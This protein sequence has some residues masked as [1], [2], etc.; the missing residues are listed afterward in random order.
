M[1]QNYI[2]IFH[3]ITRQKQVVIIGFL[4][5][6]M[7]TMHGANLYSR[8]NADFNTAGTWS[9]A[10]CG[11]ASCGC[12]PGG[13]DDIDICAGYY[14]TS[15]ATFTLGNGGTITINT[16]ATLDF[17]SNAVVIGNGATLVINGGTL[18]TGD[19]TF[20]NGSTVSVNATGSIAVTGNFQNK[21]NSN[22]I[23]INGFMGVSGWASFGNG[24]TMTGT[25]AISITGLSSGAGT[26][27][28]MLLPEEPEAV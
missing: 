18:I 3:G 24:S 13:A 17:G 8:A 9:T 7:H 10:A 6:F 27:L 26:I 12:T 15:A 14:V 2:R 5:L 16:G 20:N 11:G 19:L 4:L 1:T 22:S 21:N 28:A 23:T 25:G